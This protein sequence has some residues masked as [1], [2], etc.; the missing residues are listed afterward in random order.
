MVAGKRY[1]ALTVGNGGAQAATEPPLMKIQS[2]P[3]RG[4][5]TRGF[6]LAA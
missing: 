5:A 4:A 6:E 1:I 2:P 3:D